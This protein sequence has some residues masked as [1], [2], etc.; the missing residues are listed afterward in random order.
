MRQYICTHDTLE[1]A[2]PYVSCITFMT[3]SLRKDSAVTFVP[4]PNKFLEEWLC[5]CGQQDDRGQIL[6]VP[7]QVAQKG[8][9][10]FFRHLPETMKRSESRRAIEALYSGKR[11]ICSLMC[12]SNQ[13]C[14]RC[15]SDFKKKS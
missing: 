3:Q 8:C 15:K 11:G 10:A 9:I 13:F 5:G 6:N 12:G 4:R 2:K 14:R 1:N 7:S